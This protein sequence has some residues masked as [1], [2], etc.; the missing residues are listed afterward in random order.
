MANF[1]EYKDFHD[2]HRGLYED[3]WN[4]GQHFVFKL[5]NSSKNSA[6]GFVS[7]DIEKCLH[8]VILGF[9]YHS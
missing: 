1:K 8:F 6:G 3:D 5:K 7:I 2:F 9:R 4:N